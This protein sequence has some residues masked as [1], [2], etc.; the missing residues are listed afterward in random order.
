MGQSSLGDLRCDPALAG[1]ARLSDRQ[2]DGMRE[3]RINQAQAQRQAF[4][5]RVRDAVGGGSPGEIAKAKELLD[6]GAITR[7]EFDALKA[8]ALT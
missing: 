2:H 5:D 7:E 4:D 1:R 6:S 8:K 3:R